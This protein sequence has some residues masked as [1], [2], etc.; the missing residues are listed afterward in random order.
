MHA[1]LIQSTQT[2]LSIGTGL[3]IETLTHESPYDPNRPIPSTPM[4]M[5][6]Y[7]L[8]YVN[9]NTLVRNVV[10]SVASMDLHRLDVDDIADFCRGEMQVITTLLERFPSITVHFYTSGF[11]TM[12][13]TPVISRLLRQPST[14]KQ[15]FIDRLS[16]HAIRAI[17]NADTSILRPRY[18]LP[19]RR[20]HAIILTHII[21]DLYVYK[22]YTSLTL[23]ESNTGVMKQPSRFATKY[24]NVP[25]E[26]LGFVPFTFATG[27]MLGDNVMFKPAPIKPK[28]EFLAACTQFKWNAATPDAKVL[29]DLSS[30]QF[31]LAHYFFKSIPT[32]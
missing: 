22:K 19:T 14:D 6:K 20:N 32:V 18:L 7:S 23:L 2:G 17:L 9:I 13:S 30:S 21:T 4:S 27:A 28:R 11:G 3:A 5:D 25:P 1:V 31:E 15:K 16:G 12:W 8:L 26:I 29:T 10:Q 24:L